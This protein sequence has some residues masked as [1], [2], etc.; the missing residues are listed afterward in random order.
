M[1]DVVVA[2]LTGAR[3]DLLRQTLDTL[4]IHAGGRIHRWN[5]ICLVNGSDAATLDIVSA[6]SWVKPILSPAPIRPIGEAVS[7]LAEHVRAAGRRY[8]LHLEDDWIC[9]HPPE[10]WLDRAAHVLQD[11]KVGQVRLRLAREKVMRT[12]M[13]TGAAIRWQ[14]A[15]DHC[16]SPNAHFTFNPHLMRTDDLG[17]IYPCGGEVDAQRRFADTGMSVVQLVPGAFRHA[18]ENASLRQKLGR[19]HG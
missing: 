4:A 3:P 11:A 14:C 2:V 5:V 17:R 1:D 9:G 10:S 13:R 7:L 15:S 12:N 19:D 16:I 18:G 8:V 6:R